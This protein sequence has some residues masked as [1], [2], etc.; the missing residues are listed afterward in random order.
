MGRGAQWRPPAVG[1]HDLA[2]HKSGVKRNQQTNHQHSSTLTLLHSALHNTTL[3]PAV[4]NS[5]EA[6]QYYSSYLTSIRSQARQP[7]IRKSRPRDQTAHSHQSSRHL[8]EGWWPLATCWPRQN[9][10]VSVWRQ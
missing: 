9:C 1:G 8:A 2:S 10:A 6:M 5:S 7:A 4:P 3:S